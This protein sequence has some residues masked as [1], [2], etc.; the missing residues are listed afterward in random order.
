MDFLQPLEIES[1]IAAYETFLNQKNLSEISIGKYIGDIRRFLKY[2]QGQG[3]HAV[4][5]EVMQQYKDYICENYAV[6]SYNSYFISLNAFFR[7]LHKD[8]LVVKLRMVPQ[9]NSL[10]N[11]LTV[12]EYYQLL[13]FTDVPRYRRI[14]LVMRTLACTGIRISELQ[15]ITC[16]AVR[17]R[18]TEVT[19]KRK[20]RI[21]YFNE[22]LV[23]ELINYCKEQNIVSGC[24]FCSRGSGRP[25]DSGNI[26]REMKRIAGLAGVDQEKVYPHSFRHLFAKTYINKYNAI[27]ELADL[28]GH[29]SIETTR[30]YTRTTGEE[31]RS[32]LNMLGL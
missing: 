26:W 23:E 3:I 14:H 21:I 1:Q 19:G 13:Q 28:L 22:K 24:I 32:R 2:A 6:N 15:F 5:A 25:L 29:S 30:I 31:K 18:K 7:F 4:N 27:D 8:F 9:R 16:R 12:E 17:N 20:T 11:V 10:E